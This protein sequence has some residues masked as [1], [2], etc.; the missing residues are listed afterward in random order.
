MSSR[1]SEVEG[2]KS[3]LKNKLRVEEEKVE[4]LQEEINNLNL[5]YQEETDRH[6]QDLEMKIRFETYS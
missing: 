5:H 4:N 2:E 3:N 6:K 1:I